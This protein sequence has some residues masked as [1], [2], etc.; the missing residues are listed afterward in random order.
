[1]ILPIL[2]I[3]GELTLLYL[4]SNLLTRSLYTLFML[5]SRSRPVAVSFVT[6]LLFPGTVVHE[7]SHLFT[8]EIIGVRTGKIELAPESIRGD[9]VNIG[10][11]AIAKTDPIRRSL[12]GLSPLFAGLAVVTALSYFFPGLIREAGQAL[13]SGTA[14][15]TPPLYLAIGTFYLLFA[16][17]NSMF[18]S[19]QDLKGF[20]PVAITL[21]LIVTAAYLMGLRITLTGK[22]LEVATQILASL[23]NSLGVVL[24]VNLALLSMAGAGIMLI[25]RLFKVKIQTRS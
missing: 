23:T 8:A 11:V 24:A 9:N 3:I 14:L 2:I 4:V 13:A 6:L 18:S 5:I 25:T 19:P 16:V 10:S 21:G 20:P 7:L 1:M 22:V 17:S 12:I 15:S